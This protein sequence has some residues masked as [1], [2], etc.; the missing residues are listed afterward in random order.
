MR[1]G[2]EGFTLAELIITIA[3]VG[4]LMTGLVSIFY[5]SQ[6]AQD[7]T[8]D[9]LSD[10]NAAGGLTLYFQRDVQSAQPPAVIDATSSCGD[11]A[12]ILLRW[13][14]GVTGHRYEAA[15][16]HAGSQLD[17]ILCADLGSGYAV[18]SE[19]KLVSRVATVS[20]A[21][22]TSGAAMPGARLDVTTEPGA[23]IHARAY[24][25]SG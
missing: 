5:V 15:Y 18:R 10:Q 12:E 13:T 22:V 2:D 11:N 25:R 21:T 14:D 7:A 19:S 24:H 3:I 4:I 16:I 8:S 1:R 6:R 20:A 23:V 9:D 17:R